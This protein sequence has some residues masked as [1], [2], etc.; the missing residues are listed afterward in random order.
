LLT[1]K[2]AK[3]AKENQSTLLGGH[4]EKMSSRQTEAAFRLSSNRQERE[5]KPGNAAA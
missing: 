3:G 2:D 1:A 5:E 4:P